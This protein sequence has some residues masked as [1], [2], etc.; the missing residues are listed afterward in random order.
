MNST[1]SIFL[2]RICFLAGAG[3]DAVAGAMMLFPAAWASFYHISAFVP[4]M[5]IS[6]ALGIAAPLMLGWTVLL[7]WAALKP[8]ER[9]GVLLITVVPVIAGMILGTVEQ[10]INWGAP[11]PSQLPTLA[12]QLVLSGLFLYAYV[13]ARKSRAVE[14]EGTGL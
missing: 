3:V 4:N 10:I 9:A 12:L 8:V 5:M 14:L 11:L 6:R 7:L 2:L 13:T 1:K